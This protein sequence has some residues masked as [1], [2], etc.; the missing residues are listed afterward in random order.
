MKSPEMLQDKL[1][2]QWRQASYRVNR[3]LDPKNWPVRLTIG[4]PSSAQIQHESNAVK[5]HIHMWQQV[6]VGHVEWRKTSYRGLAEPISLPD[7]WV[8]ASPSQWVD[9]VNNTEVTYEYQ[10]LDKV[11]LEAPSIFHENLVRKRYLWSGKSIEEICHCVRLANSLEPGCAQGKPL[12]AMAGLDIDTK[13]FE[14]N[15]KLLVNL[16][17]ERF[18]GEAGKQGL[19][20]FLDAKPE[21]D[22]WLLVVPLQKGVLPF[23]RLRLSTKQL[24]QTALPFKTILV[25]ENERC[26]HLLP[27]VKDAIAILGAGLDLSWLGSE[28]FNPKRVIYWGD[29]DTWGF[30]M[31]ATARR[32]KPGLESVLMDHGTFEQCKENSSVVEPVKSNKFDQEFLTEDEQMLYQVIQ[33][34]E[35]GR[36]EQ[37]YIP[38]DIVEAS[39]VGLLDG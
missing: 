10:L 31:L 1:F 25:V 30:Q 11:L 4:K 17:D 8:L 2:R 34:L 36:L 22:H 23:P 32:A 3:L 5:Q 16:L 20:T 29:I 19:G 12:R 24:E 21:D 15:E 27:P 9:A 37:E 28:V 14:R 18:G 39:V 7:S 26:E 13:F 38:A 35:K 33:Q 6:T